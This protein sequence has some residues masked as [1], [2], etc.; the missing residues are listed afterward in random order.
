M[1]NENMGPVLIIAGMHR[2]GTSF[3]S[4]MLKESGLNVGERLT[5]GAAANAK[6]FFEN[7]DF[8]RLHAN[9]LKDQGLNPSG[10]TLEEKIEVSDEYRKLAQTTVLE[11]QQPTAWGWKDPRTTLFLDFW[12]ELLPE[13]KYLFVFRSPWEIVDSLFRR[14]DKAFQDDPSQAVK[15][16]EHYNRLA[17][18]FYNKHRD[19]CIFVHVDQVA[20]NPKALVESISKK[21]SLP[22]TPA[23]STFDQSLF[24]KEPATSHRPLII[25]EFFP[26]SYKTW[27]ELKVVAQIEGADIEPESASLPDYGNQIL[28]DW[29]E[30]RKSQAT[31]K[32]LEKAL[33][34]SKAELDATNQ[35]LET[36]NR[37]RIWKVRNKL[38]EIRQ[39]LT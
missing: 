37:S 5:D 7:I 35:Q 36:L 16:W 39:L 24:R 4:S 38:A 8:V 18:R 22:L 12:N 28:C 29:L 19:Q 21:F 32:N 27:E 26:S 13:A 14:G 6:G 31:I 34:Q 17:L 30:L 20:E 11:N 33:E 10:W 9:I 15:V 2:S 3:V 23:N 1:T 25:R